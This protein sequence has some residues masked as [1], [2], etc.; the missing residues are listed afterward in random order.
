MLT[1][2]DHVQLTIPAGDE[3]LA[4]ARTFYTG[5]LGL[6]E[7]PKP[8]ELRERGGIWFRGPGFEVHLGVEAPTETRR[9]PGFLTD[10]LEG[11]RARLVLAGVTFEEQPPLGDRDRVHVRDPFGNRIEILQ[12]RARG[13]SETGK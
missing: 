12:R 4:V 7:A 5:V 6:E 9:H 2:I 10:D 11:V 3:H 1:G 13:A 8:Q